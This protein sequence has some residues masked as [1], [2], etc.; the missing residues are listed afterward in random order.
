MVMPEIEMVLAPDRRTPVTARL[1][2]RVRLEVA[3]ILSRNS[4]TFAP[5]KRVPQGLLR[6]IAFPQE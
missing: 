1:S 6:L 3:S 4:A 5:R 2:A